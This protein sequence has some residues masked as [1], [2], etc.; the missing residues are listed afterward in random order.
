MWFLNLFKKHS[1]DCIDAYNRLSDNEFCNFYLKKI[2]KYCFIDKILWIATNVI[3]DGIVK[4]FRINY[5][6]ERLGEVIDT[7]ISFRKYG[8]R[9]LTVDDFREFLKYLSIALHKNKFI[10][11]ERTSDN[12]ET[13][14][15]YNRI[16]AKKMFKL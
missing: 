13:G 16:F 12:C 15:V 1:N 10:F 8:H 4:S 5:Y 9:G 7:K 11:I 6:N 14:C 3:E 2:P